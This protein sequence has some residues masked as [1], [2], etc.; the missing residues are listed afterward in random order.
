MLHVK[1]FDGVNT[2]MFLK[3][4][5]KVACLLAKERR[6]TGY[7]EINV[8]LAVMILSHSNEYGLLGYEV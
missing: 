4:T 8:C 2:K 1:D 5:T 6:P 7:S 3:K